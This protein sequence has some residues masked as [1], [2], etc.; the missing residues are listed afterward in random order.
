MRR[1]GRIRKQH[2]DELNETRRYWIVLSG[3]L[4]LEERM[5][6]SLYR[7]RVDEQLGGG[8]LIIIRNQQSTTCG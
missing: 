7:L 8:F 2:L 3:K 6:L 5:D 4:G 1:Q